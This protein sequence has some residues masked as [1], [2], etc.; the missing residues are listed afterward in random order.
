M[1]M[2]RIA[3]SGE[4]WCSQYGRSSSYFFPQ[5]SPEGPTLL[6][7]WGMLQVEVGLTGPRLMSVVSSLEQSC[8]TFPVL[9][10]SVPVSGQE[11]LTKYWLPGL[12]M[13][14]FMSRTGGSKKD[15]AK[16][17]KEVRSNFHYF[18][19]RGSY[20]IPNLHNP[21]RATVNQ[22]KDLLL[23]KSSNITV[24]GLH[25]DWT[26][27]VGV[28]TNYYILLED[29]NYFDFPLRDQHSFGKRS[30][31]QSQAFGWIMNIL[32]STT[33]CDQPSGPPPPHIEH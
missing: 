9:W 7:R 19:S 26:V 1:V 33:L 18:I 10:S 24:T 11:V 20:L 23:I 29:L 4:L 30:F 32:P 2:V 12:A 14:M 25:T 31:K 13:S 15:E 17:R 6:L 8:V 21:K 28:N 5:F 3:V 16:Y 22:P 27:W